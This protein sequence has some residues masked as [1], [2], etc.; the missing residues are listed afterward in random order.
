MLNSQPL[1]SRRLRCKQFVNCAALIKSVHAAAPSHH[2]YTDWV[3]L[4][5]KAWEV[6][7]DASPNILAFVPLFCIFFLFNHKP[8]CFN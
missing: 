3:T 7:D 2:A 5:K 8:C 6:H 1:C 4:L